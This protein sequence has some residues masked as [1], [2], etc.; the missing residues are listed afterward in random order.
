[1][2]RLFNHIGAVDINAQTINVQSGL[3]HIDIE[4]A[5]HPI[6]LSFAPYTS[7]R[8][9]CGIG[10]MIGNNASGERSVKYGPTSANIDWLKVMLADGNEYTFGPLT[11]RQ[12]EAKK[13]LP[14]FEGKIYREMT[15]LL[16]DNWHLI[17]HSHPDVKKNAA[18]YAL[19]DLWDV[20]RS[21]FNLGRLFIG[22]QGT[23]GITTEAELQLTLM[24]KHLS[25]L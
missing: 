24:P 9:I 1:M 14:T 21:H 8:D 2:S 11:T 12:V 5:T 15:Q 10:G 23:L 18:G 16:D 19:W 20:S 7:S 25:M 6:G 17:E 3:M 13:R 4:K 22:A